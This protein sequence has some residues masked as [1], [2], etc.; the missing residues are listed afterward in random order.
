MKTYLILLLFLGSSIV[1]AQEQRLTELRATG[2]VEVIKPFE[3]DTADRDGKKFT[4]E[5]LLKLRLTIPP[6]E[7]FTGVYTADTA[8]FFH[9]APPEGKPFVQLFSF[10]VSA[11]AY[12]KA[13]VKAVSPDMLEIH[14]NDRLVSSKTTVEDSV[15]RG[16]EVT[17]DVMPYPQSARVVIKLLGRGD[18]ESALKVTVENDSAESTRTLHVSTD[19]RRKMV[20]DDAIRGK[21]VTGVAISPKGSHVL[22]S[23]TENRGATSSHA[24]ELYRV[25]DGRRTTVDTE[26]RKTQLQWMPMSEKLWYRQKDGERTHL[27]AIHP[28]TLEET[29]LARDIPAEHVTFAPDEKALFYSKA[30]PSPDG[31]GNEAVFRM[32]TLT[33]RTGGLPSHSFI[34]RH[35]LASGLTRQ[36]TF[37]A[38]ATHLN[39]ISRDGKFLLF[40]IS[41]ETITERPFRKSAMFRLHIETMRVDTLWRDEKY[42]S[43]AQFSPDGKHILISGAPEAFDGI[44]LNVGEGQT[45]NSYDEQAFIMDLTTKRTDAITRNF[46]PSIQQAQWNPQ[47]GLIYFRTEDEDRMRIYVFNPATGQ[48]A[49]LPVKEDM[50]DGYGIAPLAPLMAYAGVSVSNSARAYLYDLKTKRSVLIADPYG[51]HLSQLT[52]GEVKDWSF[53]NS[54]GTRIKGYYYL[55]PDFDGT[56]KYPV[57]VYYYGGTSPTGRQFEG[58]YPLH[59]YA[60]L[61][62]VVYVVQPSGATG[63]GQEFSA[64]HVNTWGRRSADDIIEGTKQFVAAHPFANAEKIG[65]IGASYGG[66]MTM[67]LQTQTDLFAAAVSHA[68]ISSISS[69]WGVGYWGYAYSAAASADSYPWNNRELYVDRSPLFNADK[70]NTPL[71]LVHGTAD[72]NVPPGESIQMY[73]A[74]KILGKPVE[75]IQVQGENHHILAYEKRLKWNASIFAWFEKW[76][77]D[78]PAWWNELYRN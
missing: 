52:L 38:H 55:P 58:R 53:I 24:T 8:G 31:E 61:G 27:V 34:Y 75:L 60:A 32:R 3:V 2:A 44:G 14:V 62:Y 16:R 64:W 21:R 42:A 39:D 17:A 70:I 72:T 74:L 30:A 68:G 5:L 43:G 35:D 18:A 6:P 69:Y 26:R 67:Y 36:L 15:S 20:L 11:G 49:L 65:C 33:H 50:V 47:D 66:F 7:G 71:L 29:V 78:D 13:R 77:K 40:S 1:F 59:V 12:G 28:E 76:L 51:E 9:L 46:N 41:D 23:Y 63:F 10:Y 25:K 54:A 56:K 22:I 4:Q 73:T 19:H 48:F 37:G 45:A 57:I